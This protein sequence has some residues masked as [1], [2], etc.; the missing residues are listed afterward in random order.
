MSEDKPV[1]FLVDVNRV[2]AHQVQIVFLKGCSRSLS[3]DCIL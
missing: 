3:F 1:T 2:L